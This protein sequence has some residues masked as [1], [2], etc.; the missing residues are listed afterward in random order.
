M[1]KVMDNAVIRKGDLYAKSAPLLNLAYGGTNR[2]IA[3]LGT[4][5]NGMTFAEWNSNAPYIKMNVIPVLLDYPKFFDFMPNS[6]QWIMILKS[7]M[8]KLPLTID[9]LNSTI[10]VEFDESPATRHEVLEEAT[11]ST[12]ERSSI[13]YNFKERANRSIQ[14]FLDI[15]IRYGI[16]DPDTST[17]L[18]SQFIDSPDQYNGIYLPN[19]KSCTMMFI[20]PDLMRK[21]VVNAWFCTNMQPKTTGEITG[22]ADIRSAAEAPELSIGFTSITLNNQATKELAQ[23]LLDKMQVFKLLPDIDILPS[24]D[25]IHPNIAAHN[26]GFETNPRTGVK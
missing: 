2:F 6:D 15:W 11:N 14:N 26:S 7:L 13:T 22:K 20:E 8:E 24:D 16:M 18:V 5:I 17:A 9:G 19:F 21:Q 12:R 10:N 4:K 1:G 25:T 3:S 23:S